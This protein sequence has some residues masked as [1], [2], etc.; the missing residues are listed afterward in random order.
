MPEPVTLDSGN[1][2]TINWIRG[3]RPYRGSLSTLYRYLVHYYWKVNRMNRAIKI[4][5]KD[6]R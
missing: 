2:L 5:T 3:H 1:P 4:F 6:D